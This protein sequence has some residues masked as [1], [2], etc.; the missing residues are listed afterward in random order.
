M[1]QG[2][3]QRFT[4]TASLPRWRRRVQTATL[5]ALFVIPLLNIL[6]IYFVKGTFYSLD[7]GDL[8]LADPLAV[9]Q[10]AFAARLLSGHMLTSLVVPLLVLALL[11]RVWC[12]W[13]CPYHLLVDWLAGL[14]RRLG[15]RE[16]RPPFSR[17]RVR[18]A[19]R[20]RVVFFIGAVFLAGVAGIPLLNL[21]SAPGIISSQI[22]VGLKFG[23]LTFEAVF[24]LLLL[25]G[26]FFLAH[27][28]W[29]RLFCPS[30][31]CLSLLRPGSGLRVARAGGKC[32]DCGAC[33]V[34]CPMELDP[35]SDGLSPLCHNC[36]ACLAACPENRHGDTLR[37]VIGPVRNR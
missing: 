18:G 29:C 32:T 33:L 5:L 11:G 7:V 35:R 28:F 24:I 27:R 12:S 22:L 20:I 19:V 3:Q 34:A 16:L 9:F 17:Q 21:I 31:I 23:Y 14:R 1:K 25:M 15:L 26:E 8:S 6:E 30:G 13:F 37:F 4:A 10:A 36:G 2:R